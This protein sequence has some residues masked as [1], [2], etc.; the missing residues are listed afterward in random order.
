MSESLRLTETESETHE[1]ESLTLIDTSTLPAHSDTDS[2]TR[3]PE[4]RA[5]P[6]RLRLQPQIQDRGSMSC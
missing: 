5:R 1:T 6:P 4:E 3:C 2:L